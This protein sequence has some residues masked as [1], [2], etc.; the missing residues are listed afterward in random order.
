MTLL[1]SDTGKEGRG[2]VGIGTLIVFIALVLVAAIAAGVLINTAGFLQ[3]QA[4][5]T[6]QESTDQVANNIQIDSVIGID[7]QD[8]DTTDQ[9]DQLQL[10]IS[11]GPGSD[12]INL[13]NAVIEY[14]GSG[15]D[16]TTIDG[17]ATDPEDVNGN[18]QN[19]A[20]LDD[21]TGDVIIT[22][23]LDADSGTADL[24]ASETLTA[25]DSA[26]LTITTNDGSVVT[27][28]LDVPNPITSNDP[29]RLS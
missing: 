29:V 10:R 7:P 2:Q 26:E 5:S 19:P 13:D 4:E 28:Q 12:P 11:K 6:G 27:T 16:R 21:S 18:A 25:G 22:I 23:N 24:P 17:L 8:G 1:N 3:S 9:I 20:V 14:I 15:S